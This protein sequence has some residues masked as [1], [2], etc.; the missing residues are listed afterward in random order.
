MYVS[1]KALRG[2]CPG[3]FISKTVF[4]MSPSLCGGAPCHFESLDGG[5]ISDATS[6]LSLPTQL[7]VGHFS[8]TLTLTPQPHRLRAASYKAAPTSNA[9]HKSWASPASDQ[10]A[11]GQGFLW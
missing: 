3:P 5:V 11:V 7:V 10:L 9:S 8:S 6:S 1:R 4:V 2:P